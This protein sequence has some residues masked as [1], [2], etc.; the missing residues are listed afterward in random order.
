MQKRI[1]FIIIISL[2]LT[3]CSST[4]E[5]KEEEVKEEEVLRDVAPDGADGNKSSSV[6]ENVKE[7]VTT[8]TLST[9]NKADDG[10]GFLQDD[11]NYYYRWVEDLEIPSGR[12][13]EASVAKPR[14]V[15]FLSDT[16]SIPTDAYSD[17]LYFN[18]GIILANSD[19]EW[20]A[21]QAYALQMTFD[22]FPNFYK[23]GEDGN[24]N[25][26]DSERDS[27]WILTDD[28]LEDDLSVEIIDGA[29]QVTVSS[30]IFVNS[31][32]K[33]AEIEGVKGNYFSKRLHHVLTRF[34]TDFGRD[35]FFV[36]KLLFQRFGVRLSPPSFSELTKN[37]CLEGADRFQKFHPWEIVA[38]INNFEDMPEGMHKIQGLNYLVRRLDGTD[39]A[40]YP[41]YAALA[42]GDAG[43]IEFM[44]KTFKGTEKSTQLIEGVHR[45]II[46]EKG[47]FLW[48]KVFDQQLK[49]DW[50]EVGGWYQDSES[51]TGWYT[52]K[53]TEFVTAYAHDKDPNEDMAETV[54]YYI[55]NPDKLRSRSPD[56]YEFIK[57]RVMK[58]TIYISQIREDL[59]FEVYNL[60][61]DYVYPG[62]IK[63]VDIA[64]IGDPGEE[65]NVTIEI[66]LHAFNKNKEGAQIG[67][68]RIYSEADTFV[69]LYFYPKNH[70]N[71]D[72]VLVGKF[73]LDEFA[74]NGWWHAFN[75]SLTDAVGNERFLSK[76]DFGWKMYNANPKEDRTAPVYKEN[77]LKLYEA[78]E[79]VIE[80]KETRRMQASWEFIEENEVKLC[81]AV[82]TDEDL[83]TYSI[84][85]YGEVDNLNNTCTVNF[86]LPEYRR[87]STYRVP[88]VSTGDTAGN[89]GSNQF[90]IPHLWNWYSG[91]RDSR[92]EPDR[93]PSPALYVETSN[94]DFNRP[95]L[96]LNIISIEAVPTIPDAPNG[97]TIV[98]FNYR[99]RDDNSGLG[100]GSLE[101]RDPQGQTHQ[102]YLYETEDGKVHASYQDNEWRDL[103]TVFILPEGS[104]P[105][106]WGVSELT[107]HDHSGNFKTYDFTEIVQFVVDGS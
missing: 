77:S 81:Y 68:T 92:Q 47:H 2:F 100:R 38:I 39:N 22:K 51:D 75:I 28:F 82:L 3:N 20:T 25:F 62:K 53:N 72:T 27:K 34:V 21:E 91:E 49:D 13:Y 87:T 85:E 88:L 48:S 79:E 66:E 96:D 45:I 97:E 86:W 4:E 74:A 103:T 14:E 31:I 106:T 60:W 105:G 26:E 63:G 67:F 5:V 41:G 89:L 93:E 12:E 80:G 104:A 52:T 54:S 18:Y 107:L 7:E 43:Y 35:D 46:H 73:T 95:K 70:S 84:E 33:A 65:K 9:T 98:T 56:K 78:D 40:C 99:V 6:Q 57:T 59:T 19:K 90:Y 76:N 64:V 1:I 16:I 24:F 83:D 71:E 102:Y 36:E 42:W 37:T 69:D 61:P 58:G 32:P 11:G 55:L 50:I 8:I 17:N 23:R 15:K 44:E 30:A 94:P 29:K 10:A 101:L